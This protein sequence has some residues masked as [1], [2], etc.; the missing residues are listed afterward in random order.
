MFSRLSKHFHLDITCKLFIQLLSYLPCTGTAGLW[1][2][3]SVQSITCWL[4]F[5]THC[6]ADQ[7]RVRCCVEAGWIECL[8]C[9]LK[10]TLFNQGNTCCFLTASEALHIGMHSDFSDQVWVKLCLTL[11]IPRYFRGISLSGPSNFHC[12]GRKTGAPTK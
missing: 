10:L 4:Y 8:D 12:W 5:L 11:F 2:T 9:N 3:M 1:V 7:D 6:S